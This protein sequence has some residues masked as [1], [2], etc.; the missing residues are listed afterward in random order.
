MAVLF[1]ALIR[2]NVFAALCLPIFATVQ[3]QS[4][5]P[6]SL[7]PQLIGT[8]I[9][10]NVQ[11]TDSNHNQLTFQF[12]VAPPNGTLAMAKDFVTG[13]KSAGV[14]SAQPFV[15]TPT[16]IEGTYQIQ[17]VVKDFTSLESVSTILNFTVSPLVTGNAPVAV[18]TS[19]PLVALFSAPSCAAG[20]TMRVY[21]QD[22]AQAHPAVTTNY[23]TCHPPNTMTFEIAGMYPNTIYNMFSQTN[24][25]GVITN[26]RS[27]AFTTGPLPSN[28]PLPSFSVQTAAGPQTDTT[29]SVLLIGPNHVSPNEA[30]VAIDLSGNIL[31]YYYPG[32]QGNYLI[33]PL[34]NGTFLSIQNGPTWAPGLTYEQVLRQFDLAGNIV[35]ETNTGILSQELLAMGATDAALCISVPKPALV[36]A[37]CL[38]GF[39]HEAFQL[40]PHGYTAV[41]AD[42]QKVFPPGT[43]G[44]TSGLPV[45][46][47]GT[48]IIVLD[49]NWRVVWYFDA[50]Q[51]AGGAPQLDINRPAV[52][53]ESCSAAVTGCPASLL[54]TGIAPLAR[55]WLHGNSI[56]YWPPTGDLIWSA[57]HQDWVV[58]IDYQNGAGTGNILWRAGPCGDFTF[59]NIYQDPWPWF[60]HQH[61][62]GI[63]QGG[64]GALTLFD[65]GNT[66]VSPPSGTG[67]SSGC[68]PGVGK[69]HSRGMALTL[70]EAT[71]QATPVLSVD[72]GLYSGGN[73]SAQLLS[74][75][76]YFF[77]AGYVLN[78]G[79]L[80]GNSIEI[81][82]TPGTDTG[83]QVL[84]IQGPSTYRAWRMPNLYNP[85]IT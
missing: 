73:G 50:F 61:E 80:T 24:T 9:I 21:F 40:L 1:G 23:M 55:D 30:D 84:N 44:D 14:W 70:D 5:T 19:N 75:G 56:Y 83:S 65:N 20:S 11:A 45:D 38:G 34:V 58:K 52:L 69:G 81:L 51:H 71:M 39:N 31:W 72:L 7:S 57:R 63:E 3:I 13:T 15:W 26:G 49:N 28:I 64:A 16:G 85:P 78:H 77:L 66:R 29:D 33:R 27:V 76:D 48:M 36:G 62:A 82:P 35:R 54:G 53:G 12:N 4:V 8:P 41:Q 67:S 37:A 25:G 74:N 22:S 47:I 2:V 42:L 60:S 43:Q 59:N 6:S 46:I 18:K 79:A 17:V 10:W 32:S 68:M